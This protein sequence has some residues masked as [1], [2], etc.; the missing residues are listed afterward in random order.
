MVS[1][2]PGATRSRPSVSIIATSIPSNE[3]PLI[4]PSA[5]HIGGDCCGLVSAPMLG[6]A[7]MSTPR[8]TFLLTAIERGLVHQC[9]DFESLD[10]RLQTG[11]VTAYVGYDCTADSL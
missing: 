3:V 10:E 4:S 2:G 1:D 9:T 8:S 7:A 6:D 5:R 11:R